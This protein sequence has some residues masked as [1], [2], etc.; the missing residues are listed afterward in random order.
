M[1]QDD[2]F[3]PKTHT[4]N[5]V[6]TSYSICVELRGFTTGEY[7]LGY[8]GK[9]LDN[10]LKGLRDR[11]LF[12][13][14]K[15]PM[16]HHLLQKVGMR[17]W[18]IFNITAS[19]LRAGR[20]GKHRSASAA[21]SLT[22]P[23]FRISLRKKRTITLPKCNFETSSYTQKFN[24]MFLFWYLTFKITTNNCWAKIDW[25]IWRKKFWF[26]NIGENTKENLMD[27]FYFCSPY[28]AIYSTI[29]FTY[30]HFF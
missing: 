29:F 12:A 13:D 23:K 18:Q 8:Q 14:P 27:W 16:I 3:G 2:R 15:T 5:S 11:T 9:Y 4:Y 25:G 6:D 24:Y 1:W 10:W 28:S 7:L 21:R 22:M 26:S 30:I 19:R 17:C 20:R